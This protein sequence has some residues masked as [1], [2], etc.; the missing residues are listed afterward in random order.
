MTA[1]PLYDPDLGDAEHETDGEEP[2]IED[3]AYREPEI[4]FS[5]RREMHARE[6]DQGK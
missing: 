1:I 2:R 3:A 6:H 4:V 5:K